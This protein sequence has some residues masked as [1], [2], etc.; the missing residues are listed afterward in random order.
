MSK[1]TYY[2]LAQNGAEA[3]INIYGD[4]TS[5]PWGE[6]DVSAVNLSRKLEELGDV[7]RINVFINSYG[8]EVAEGLAIYNALR[9]HKAKVVTYCDGFAAS[10]ASVIF[11]AGDERV[12]NEASLLMIHNAWTYAAGNADQLRKQADDLD[13]IT[14]ASVEAYKA[15]STL[16]EEEIEAL[17][18]AETWILPEEAIEYGFATA[19]DKTE[20]EHASQSARNCFRAL[21][22][23][24]RAKQAAEPDEDEDETEEEPDTEED[25]GKPEEGDDPEAEPDEK[26]EEKRNDATTLMAG[27]F[28][29]IFN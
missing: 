6:G 5:Y 7:E 23:A 19:I 9:R 10:I 15:H 18:D 13:K 26:P 24:A 28:K 25:E 1:R 8:G 16:T 4:I 20:S 2:A 27:F 14:K 12:M 29:A 21:V 22:E 11:M 3:S 17:M